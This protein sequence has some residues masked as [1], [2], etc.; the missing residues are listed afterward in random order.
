MTT[1]KAFIFDMDGVITET[2]ENHF[3]AWKALGETLGF[4]LDRSFNEKLKGVSRR[5]SLELILSAAGKTPYSEEEKIALMEQK[6]HHYLS[7]I[8]GFTR[9]NLLP[10]VESLLMEIKEAHIR[11]AIASASQSA[12]L[13]V[14]KLGIAHYVDHIVN[15]GGVAGKPDPAIFL[16]AAN[17]FGL[18]P[19]ACVGIEDAV[20]GIQAIKGAG[21]FA[22]GVGDRSILSQ[23]DYVIE[24]F[25]G[26]TLKALMEVV[27]D[28]R[29]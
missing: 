8:Q 20:A 9:N 3:L 5:D 14:E 11:V 17:H 6:N 26:V 10:G 21:M 2:S 4:E 29:L 28:T 13:L 1:I 7:M 23:A 24:S 27:Y 22:L 19:Q 16:S 18:A 25:E 15:P 12:P